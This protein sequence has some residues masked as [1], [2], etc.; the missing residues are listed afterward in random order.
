MK[1]IF[2]LNLT[3]ERKDKIES[4]KDQNESRI[5]Q[6]QRAADMNKEKAIARLNV[7]LNLIKSPN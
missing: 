4:W 7:N 6:N 1:Q 5:A 3:K 2:S